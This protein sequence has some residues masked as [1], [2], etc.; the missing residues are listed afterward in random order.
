VSGLSSTSSSTSSTDSTIPGNNVAPI[1][2]PGIVSGIDYNAI[3]A[4]LT[5]VT[6]LPAQQAQTQITSLN[7]KNSTLVTLNAYLSSVQNTLSALSDPAT[8][9]SFAATSSD[10]SV[11]TGTSNTASAGAP[12]TYIIEKTQLAT[13]TSVTSALSASV[14]YSLA[15]VIP[16]TGGETGLE[17]PLIDSVTSIYPSNGSS[18]ADEG[19]ITVDGVQ[20]AYN[21]QSQSLDTILANITA[22]VAG[23][24]VSP[25]VDPDFSATYDAATDSVTFSSTDA[26]ISI[27]S[28]SDSGN[29]EQ[30]LKLD[31]AQVNNT[32]SS[33]SVTSAGPIGGLSL[34]AD[35]ASTNG[36]NLLTSVSGGPGSFFTINGV[37]ITIDPTSQNLQDVINAINASSAGVVATFNQITNQL[38]LTNTSTGPQSIVI[39]SASDTTN[40]L[41]AV[42]LEGSGATTT[43]GQQAYVT[44]QQP[45]GSPQTYYSSSDQ[46]SGA[47]AGITLTV[48]GDSTT[49]TTL[50]VTQ[51]SQPAISAINA[52]VSAYN[53]AINEINTASEAPVVQQTDSTT[54]TSTTS[55]SSKLSAGG[56]L[57][58]D[59]IVEELKDQLI[60]IVS[61]VFSGGGTS[62]NSLSSIGLSLDSTHSVFAASGSANNATS[63]SSDS[64][65]SAGNGTITLQTQD[66]TSG[67]LQPLDVATFTAAFEADP[68]AVANI[69][70]S[71][72]GLVSQLGSY[73]TSAT[74]LPTQATSGLVGSIPDVSLIQNDENQVSSQVTSLQD[75]I[76][77]IDDE[78]NAQADLLRAEYTSSETLIAGYQ[79]LQTYVSQL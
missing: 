27:G 72:N 36:A 41:K 65:S 69:F 73:L 31:V 68:T 44:V 64:T 20:I 75:Y 40:F 45:N 48:A 66:G 67:E 43:I 19:K 13:A 77:Q 21:I 51:N 16:G 76:K 55:S 47:I 14:G 37:K 4:K 56:A 57:Y 22:A 60:S 63:D 15:D 1:S 62:Y 74:G 26:P 7:Q 42:G 78:A 58:N 46:I 79:S 12:G 50:T 10:S 6:L 8:F 3:I 2:F 33:G 23:T 54:S 11:L 18:G 5:S 34:S 24:S 52:F 25:G 59:L 9:D 70:N 29:L 30:V 35:F 71:A 61:D 28:Q 38:S 32:S 39:G 49:P 17:V 53:A